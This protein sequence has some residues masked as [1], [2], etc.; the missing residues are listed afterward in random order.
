MPFDREKCLLLPVSA[1]GSE[2]PD[3]QATRVTGG[4]FVEGL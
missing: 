4:W 2:V 3:G 1:H